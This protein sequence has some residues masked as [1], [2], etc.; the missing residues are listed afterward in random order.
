MR[1]I[2]MLLP[3]SGYG[4][5]DGASILVIDPLWISVCIHGR[6]NGL[7]DIELVA[8]PAT[9]AQRQL[10]LIEVLYKRA[11]MPQVVAF[12]GTRRVPEIA[13]HIISVLIVVQIDG[14]IVMKVY[15]IG[16]GS[17]TAIVFIG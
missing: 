10:P 12:T 13:L 15:R 2:E 6:E 4:R 17:I 1:Q 11:D 7:P 16:A 5:V 9:G 3:I 14:S 8:T